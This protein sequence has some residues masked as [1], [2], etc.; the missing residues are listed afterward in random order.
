VWLQSVLA[1]FAGDV[2]CS[3]RHVAFWP[4]PA[5]VFGKRK[6]AATWSDQRFFER[7]LKPGD[8][9]LATAD[10]SPLPN[11]AISGTA[12]KHLAVYVGSVHG[13]RSG[14]VIEKPRMAAACPVNNASCHPHAIVHAVSEG[15]LC[16]DL[17]EL[18]LASDYAAAVRPWAFPIQQPRIIQA[19]LDAV[20]LEYNFDFK[21]GGPEALYCTELGTHCCRAAGVEA[22]PTTLMPVS[23]LG[24]LLPLRRYREHVT[25][26]D[27]FFRF[28]AVCSTTSC[29][30]ELWRRMRY[31]SMAREQILHAPDAAGGDHDEHT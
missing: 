24:L 29:R 17:G 15:V 31:G 5:V 12:M 3:K 7:L 11:K 25:L 30:P 10:R 16:Q 18:L 4:W 27:A 26:A 19:A 14:H 1:A 9:I 23:L 20:G 6:P 13:R 28:P 8:F 2:W 22:P 21:A